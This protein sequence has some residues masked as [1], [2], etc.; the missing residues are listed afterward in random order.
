MSTRFGVHSTNFV[1]LKKYPTEKSYQDAVV[2]FL[3]YARTNYFKNTNKKVFA[4][5]AVRW[6][7]NPIYLRYM[8]YMDGSM[9]EFFAYSRSGWY[10]VKEWLFHTER[11]RAAVNKGKTVL[12]IAQGSQTDLKRQLFGYASYLLVA[13]PTTYFRYTSDTAYSKMWMYENYEARLGTP[14][15]SYVRVGN[16]FTRSFTNGKV[17]VN[18]ETRNASITIFKSTC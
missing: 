9:D 12:L 13:S 3:N 8:D 14:L 5:V 7:H 1:K 4:N 11:A 16:T 10:S 6:G 2:G 18:P 17:T 15:G